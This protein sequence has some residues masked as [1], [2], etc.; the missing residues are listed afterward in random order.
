MSVRCLTA[1]IIQH[2]TQ[3]CGFF[4][5]GKEAVSWFTKTKFIPGFSQDAPDWVEINFFLDR[6]VGEF[7]NI[8]PQK[9]VYVG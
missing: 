5:A 7:Q 4:E 3:G 2:I 1:D 8:K 6:G 9:T